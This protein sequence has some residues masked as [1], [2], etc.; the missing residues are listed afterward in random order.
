MIRSCLKQLLATGIV[1]RVLALVLLTPVLS[2]IIR[3]AFTMSGEAAFAD[4]DILDFLT[5]PVGIICT[6]L[7]LAIQLAF[8]VMEIGAMLSIINAKAHQ[9]DATVVGAVRYSMNHAWPILRLTTVVV[10][11]LL[12]IGLP[13]AAVG[14]LV[15]YAL[16][17][18]YDINYYLAHRP[19][20][21]WIALVI[22]GLLVAVATL[23]FLRFLANWIYALPLL[24]FRNE[25]PRSALQRSGLAAVGRRKKTV[26]LLA[27][28]LLVA[29]LAHSGVLACLV[30]LGSLAIPQ[31]RDAMYLLL[32]ITGAFLATWFVCSEL[33]NLLA[34]V[35]L[36]AI[37]YQQF[38]QVESTSPQSVPGY[39]TSIAVPAMRGNWY[40]TRTRLGIMLATG[41]IL[42]LAT[43]YLF[44]HSMKFKDDVVIHAHR[45]S[46]ALAPENTMAAILQAIDDQAD[47]V[48]IDVQELQD[49]QIVVFHDSD[50][51]RQAG[52][53]LTIWNATTDDIAD[54]DIGSWFDAR[55]KDQRAPLLSDV[56]PACRGKIKVNIE[57]K[58]YGHEQ[59]LEQRVIDL[60]E[61]NAMQSEI[62][63][64]SL[65]KA[66]VQKMKS[67]RPS[68][69]VGLLSAVAVGDLS[70]VQ[71][72]FLAVGASIATSRLVD[73]AEK[74]GKSVLVWT[75]NDPPSIS[76]MLS[77]GVDG[78]ITDDPAT[79]RD[80]L[81]FR[82]NLS[83]AERLVLE[84]AQKFGVHGNLD[85]AQ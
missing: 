23:I 50:F 43:G 24:L 73:D 59:Q 47:F 64:M 78:I 49:G 68:W 71:A 29:M 19:T 57:L 36:A 67:L 37:I 20:E 33:I 77:I 16:T 21:W 22:L 12:L 61:S 13:F 65:K 5:S 82:A 56:L 45:G 31:V 42:S 58:Y 52:V 7:N 11:A 14:G 32:P 4:F 28:W 39:L 17:T 80:V 76:Q 79:V 6:I 70:Q 30:W 18:R 25:S 2:L 66:A 1:F 10:T 75:V 48:E 35:A 69:S 60:V 84:I 34:R 3:L 51:M 74:Q 38:T 44:M 27:A 55:F 63:V 8:S 40:L 81:N 62:V 72:D 85:S 54:I 53:D 26:A 46:S 41:L 9:K 15:G 83:A